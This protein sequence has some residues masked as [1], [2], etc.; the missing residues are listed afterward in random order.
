[1]RQG[2][3]ARPG[4][5]T[6]GEDKTTFATSRT[7]TAVGAMCAAMALSASEGGVAP[8]EVPPGT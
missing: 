6:G 7:V 5:L 8:A 1:M 4:I 2:P 3:S